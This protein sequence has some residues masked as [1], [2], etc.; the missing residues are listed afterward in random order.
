MAIRLTE[1]RLRQIIRE[2]ASNLTRHRRVNEM[3]DPASYAN[4]GREDAS[5][6][7]QETIASA[8]CNAYGRD[9]A[10][11]ISDTCGGG[12]KAFAMRMFPTL[13]QVMGS[14]PKTRMS[15]PMNSEDFWY[16]VN[17]RMRF[18]VDVPTPAEVPQEWISWYE[19]G[20]EPPRRPLPF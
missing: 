3:I 2:E 7:A 4:M 10:E 20:T 18:M 1:T 17:D 16:G 5:S 8:L 14:I 12:D 9:L 15:P 19:D 11:A 6:N 13:K